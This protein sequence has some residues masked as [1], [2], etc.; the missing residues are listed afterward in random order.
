MVRRLRAVRRSAHAVPSARARREAWALVDT[1]LVSKSAHAF[2]AGAGSLRFGGGLSP[3]HLSEAREP[4][5][6]RHARAR[7]RRGYERYG[8]TPHPFTAGCTR[9]DQE[10][11]S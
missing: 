8:P 5:L 1:R 10:P 6:R 7:P 3:F 4:T 9:R 2:D 11:A